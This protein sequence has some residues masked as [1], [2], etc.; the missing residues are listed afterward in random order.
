MH[1][2]SRTYETMINCDKV[3]CRNQWYLVQTSAGRSNTIPTR[4]HPELAKNSP[5]PNELSIGAAGDRQPSKKCFHASRVTKKVFFS[6]EHDQE[7]CDLNG[8]CR[9]NTLFFSAH[10]LFPITRRINVVFKLFLLRC[11]FPSIVVIRKFGTWRKQ[12]YLWCAEERISVVSHL[13]GFIIH[14]TLLHSHFF[15]HLHCYHVLD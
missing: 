13:F 11:H 4:Q 6:S 1:D 9:T 5:R 10:H 7:S 14:V 15:L 12:A 8:G 3:A 2:H